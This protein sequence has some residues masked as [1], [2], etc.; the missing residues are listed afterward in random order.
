MEIFNCKNNKDMKRIILACMMALPF[1][2][3]AQ[4]P[5][6]QT[7]T[8]VKAYGDSIVIRKGSGD[9]KIRIYEEISNGNDRKEEQIY[10]GIYLTRI[11]TDRPGILNALPFVPKR[12]NTFDPHASGLYIGF[13]SLSDDFYSFGS[14]NRASLDASK[15]WE[16]GANLFTSSFSLSRDRH[17]GMTFGLGWGYRSFRL[18]GNQA[19]LKHEGATGIFA[20]DDETVY[21]KSR[22]RY[23]HF[24]IPISI[25]WQTRIHKHRP[26]FFA[27]GPEVEIRHGIKSMAKVNGH[28]ETLDKGMYVHPVGINLLAQAGYGNLG[29]YLRYSTYGLFEKGKGPDVYP[30]SFGACWYW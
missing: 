7:A 22:L 17:W 25:E 13:S 10:E 1:M 11:D 30:L 26:V 15:S 16:I 27:A 14:T 6:V 12:R 8:T 5:E 18:D 19:F 20:G 24:R 23:F 4:E 21:S 29:F 3:M 2:A 28:K 9:V